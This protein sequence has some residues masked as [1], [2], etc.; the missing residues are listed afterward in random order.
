MLASGGN[1]SSLEHSVPEQLYST[2]TEP[3]NGISAIKALKI[4]NDQ[5]IPIYTISQS[6]IGSIVRNTD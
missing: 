6:N 1:S 3:I 5:G 4:A 2:P